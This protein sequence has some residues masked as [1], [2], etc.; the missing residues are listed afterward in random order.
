LKGTAMSDS[1]KSK[2]EA[3]SAIVFTEAYLKVWKEGG[4]IADLADKLERS[5]EQIRAKRNSVAAQYKER[6]VDLP[7]LKRMA[8]S[9]FGGANYDEG[10]AMVTAAL[11]ED[12]DTEVTEVEMPTSQIED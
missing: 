9:G 11:A 10:A 1:T 7:S 5:V 6:G 8:R 3:I 4:T 2:A 12:S